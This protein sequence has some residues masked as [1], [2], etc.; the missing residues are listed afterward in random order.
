M[1]KGHV[2]RLYHY[3]YGKNDIYTDVIC[4]KDKTFCRVL[5]DT[6]NYKYKV[7]EEVDA[8]HRSFVKCQEI[9]DSIMEYQKLT[10][11]KLPKE[12]V[13]VPV[14]IKEKFYNDT[15]ID[16]LYNWYCKQLGRFDKYV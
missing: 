1:K 15:L 5:R 6:S 11:F 10:D 16:K 13:E 3:Y 12:K 9:A 8:N 2:Y 14:Y 7:N 4:L